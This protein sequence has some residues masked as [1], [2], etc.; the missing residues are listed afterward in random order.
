MTALGL[1]MPGSSVVHRAPAGAKLSALLVLGVVALLL[2][3]PWEIGVLLGLAPLGYAVA[4]VPVRAML[5]FLRPMVWLILAVCVGNWLLAGPEHA[6]MVTGTLMVLALVANLVTVT[7]RTSELLDTTAS[8]CSRLHWARVDGERVGLYL[9]LA[10][11]SVPVALTLAT[12]IRDAQRARG[13]DSS[14]R[15]FAVPLVVRVLIHAEQLG[16]ALVARGAT[17]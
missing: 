8:V 14:I 9:A 6:L 13:L 4:G 11:R 7:T 5:G 1:Y 3:Q 16:E 10:V 17:D 12:E 15:A 2:D